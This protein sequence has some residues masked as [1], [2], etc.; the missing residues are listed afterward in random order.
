MINLR[1]LLKWCVFLSLFMT[2]SHAWAVEYTYD[3]FS[4]LILV[5]YDSGA[6]VA[7]SYDT[8]GN[9]TSV[10]HIHGTITVPGPPVIDRFVTTIN[11]VTIYFSAPASNGGSAIISYTA[12]CSATGYETR[13]ATGP[14]SPLTVL[15]LVEGVAYECTVAATN[16]IGTGT[17][18]SSVIVTPGNFPWLLY[19]PAI[20]MHPG[21]QKKMQ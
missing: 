12:T 1:N 6:S 21:I 2:W 8:V 13:T 19:F 20:I 10:A 5:E 14:G 18:S 17:A 4:R 16:G 3:T 7:Y 15:D 9:I 11:S